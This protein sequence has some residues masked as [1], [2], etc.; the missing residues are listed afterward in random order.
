MSQLRYAKEYECFYYTLSEQLLKE[1]KGIRLQKGANSHKH[2]S[3]HRNMQDDIHS[4]YQHN[5]IRG[6]FSRNKG[7]EF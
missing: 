7:T 6:I 2:M 4:K 5:D 3:I 1:K